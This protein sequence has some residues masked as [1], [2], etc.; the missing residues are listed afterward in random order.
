LATARASRSLCLFEYS[1]GGTGLNFSDTL[2]IEYHNYRIITYFLVMIYAFVLYSTVGLLFEKY[3]SVPEIMN[4]FMVF[5][6]SSKQRDVE[7]KE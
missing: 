2:W 3:G 5:F 1:G 7:L 4:N 6:K